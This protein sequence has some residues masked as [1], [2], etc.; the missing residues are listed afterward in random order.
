M[1]FL[2]LRNAGFGALIPA[3]VATLVACGGADAEVPLPQLAAAIGST[4]NGTCASLS[5]AF[6]SL[7]NTQITV[8]ETVADGSLSVGGKPVGEHCLVT[9][10]MYERTSSVDGNTYAIGFEMRLPKNWNGRFLHQGNGGTDGAV[11]TAT[12][13]TG[14]GPVTHAL[15][16]GFAVLSSDAGH[17]GSTPNYGVDPQARLDYGYQ[18]VGKLTPMAKSAIQL[19]YGKRPDRSYFAGC[20]NGGRHAMVA[21]TRYY[22]DYDG[23]LAG[24][25]GYNLPKAAVSNLAGARLYQTL[26]TVPVTNQIDLATAFTDTERQF[27]SSKVLAKCDALDGAADGLVQDVSACQLAFKPATDLPV[28]TGARDSTCLSADQ[29]TVLA[30]IFSGPTTSSGALIYSSFPFD[31][32]FGAGKAGVASGGSPVGTGIAFWEFFASTNLDSG[33]TGIIFQVPPENPSTFSPLT[34]SLTTDIDALYAGMTTTDATYKE[35]AMAFMTPPNP[36]KMFG[37]RDRG[38]KI[39]VYHG[40]SDSIFSVNDSEAWFKGVTA[41]SGSAFAKFYRVPGMG[42]CSGG[43]ATDQ[44]DMLTPLVNWVEKGVAPNDIVASARGAGNA[45]GV[46]SDLPSTW[47]ADRTRPLCAYPKVARY[48]G[49]GSLETASSFACE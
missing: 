2:I 3:T 38:G 36:T 22:A 27:V 10:K 45:G 14:G 26:A 24:A 21:A 29:K 31:A 19:A 17:S 6:A 5:T 41:D 43:P 47:A 23:V 16:K 48:K 33:A 42:H 18:A 44:F 46:N 40:V 49:S 9:G 28:C 4:F 39:M 37:L 15:L 8:S 11:V 32:G 35:S 1:R 20:S 7:A 25:P 12:G 34:F 13:A 30:K